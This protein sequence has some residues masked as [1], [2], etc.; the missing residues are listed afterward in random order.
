MMDWQG[1][2]SRLRITTRLAGFPADL[3]LM[4]ADA[5]RVRNLLLFNVVGAIDDRLREEVRRAP[6][7]PQGFLLDYT[8]SEPLG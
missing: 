5:G 1:P 7:Y 8:R 2:G 4:A 3:L 6:P